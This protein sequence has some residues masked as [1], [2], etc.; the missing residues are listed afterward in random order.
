[1]RDLSELNINEGGKPVCRPAP[2][3]SMVEEFERQFELKLP[4]EYLALL[5]HANGGHPELDS[6][7][8]VG[9]PSADGWA[10]NRFYHLDVDTAST[11]GLWWNMRVWRPVLGI[12][13]LP[14]ANTGGG[15]VFFRELPNHS[16]G[17][18]P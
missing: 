17:I 9:G 13:A 18:V 15:D 12:H 1:M 8:R 3:R 11:D 14:I 5:A 10:V 4:P 7:L 6:F 16:V 2:T